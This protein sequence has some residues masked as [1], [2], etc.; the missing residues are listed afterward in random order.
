MLESSFDT[1]FARRKK[2]QSEMEEDEEG[3]PISPHFPDIDQE[4]FP[5]DESHFEEDYAAAV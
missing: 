5:F 1:N 4:R 3:T 2:E